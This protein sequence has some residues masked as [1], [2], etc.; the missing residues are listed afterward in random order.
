MGGW[1]ATIAVH[2]VPP[3]RAKRNEVWKLLYHVN[4]ATDKFH[5][6]LNTKP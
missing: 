6:V 3:K 1:L 5:I 2:T 4:M